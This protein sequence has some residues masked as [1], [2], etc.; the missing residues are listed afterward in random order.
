MA[1]KVVMENMLLQNKKRRPGLRS[2]I[3]A[4]IIPNIILDSG[5]WAGMTSL[6]ISNFFTVQILTSQ[7][8]WVLSVVLLLTNFSV[9]ILR[10]SDVV[11]IKKGNLALPPSQQPTPLFAFG[12]NAVDQGDVVT[13]A[14]FDQN[15]GQ[16]FNFIEMVPGILW[17]IANNISL[18]ITSSVSL[19]HEENG[20]H[21]DARVQNISPQLEYSF[22]VNIQKT[23]IDRATLV[24]N[25]TFP[26]K[27]KTENT[28]SSQQTT[29]LGSNSSQNQ[30]NP[31]ANAVL[32]TFLLGATISR[33]LID[34][35]PWTSAGVI[36][37][38]RQ[39]DG[40]KPGNQY[41]LQ[42]GLGRNIPTNPSWILLG[43]IEFNA[44]FSEHDKIMGITDP[45][46][47][48]TLVYLGPSFWASNK[49]WIFQ[50]GILFP[51][52]QHL[53]GNQNKNHYLAAANIGMKF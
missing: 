13:Y 14:Y 4:K 42:G 27:S 32:P 20:Q 25:A 23:F 31:G 24:V 44:M 40:T 28:G 39:T 53:N 19:Y 50:A 9:S 21:Q 43:Q 51:I 46:S 11:Q 17:G 5:S 2:G 47:G 12:Q 38:L 8:L 6:S 33:T 41:L 7:F 48:G 35:Y 16:G 10:P 18:F 36:L 30:R 22:Y 49:R 1:L 37:T 45:D 52:Y 3:Q 26:I 15:K 34:W 29:A